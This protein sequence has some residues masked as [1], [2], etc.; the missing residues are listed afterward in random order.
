MVNYFSH[1]AEV[2]RL[3]DDASASVPSVPITEADSFRKQWEFVTCEARAICLMCSRRA[4]KTY[5]V[6]LRT[7][8]RS[9]ERPGWRTLI[10]HH[11]RILGK[12]QIYETGDA[13]NPGIREMLASH[14]IAERHHDSTDLNISLENGS[15]IQVVGCDDWREV[16]KKLG[17]LWN[18]IVMIECQE[19]PDAVLERLVDKTILPTLIDRGGSLTMEG[20]PA[21]VEAGVWFDT[22]MGKKT[23]F[24]Q[25]RWTL[26][27]NP[28]IDRQNIIDTMAIRGFKINFADPSD[29]PILI[30]REIFGRQVIDPEKLLYC[31]Q[32]GVNDW[33]AAGIPL[34]DS[35]AWRYAM[36]IDI[37]GANA[38]NDRDACVVWG[39]MVNDPE[40]LL[41]ER[42]SWE[43][44]EMD[45]EAFV[46]RVLGTYQRWPPMIAACG[47]TGGAG[48][49]KMLKVLAG[50]FH[51][52]EFTPK[53]TSVDTSTRLL[54]DEFRSG[55]ARVNPLGLIARDAKICTKVETY[56][57]DI[58]AA[59]R[60]GHH[61]VYNYMA[62]AD[63]APQP[64]N[65]D[66]AIRRRRREQ[67]Q[68]EK[69]NLR[70]PWSG[71]GGWAP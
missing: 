53:P 65:T 41:W 54:N 11:T 24:T 49:N 61:G 20:T 8:K 46:K 71:E 13:K 60:Y 28:F 3:P 48:A 19:F 42:E 64:E 6:R 21:E 29:N 56:H 31:Y 32:P 68:N 50:R 44:R 58:M 25:F 40:H 57:S 63:P 23:Q 33:P 59:A 15:F 51:G 10:I 37:G 62:K 18:D 35:Q 26:L 55:R 45:S 5:G 14:H 16:G 17:F 34:V 7:V 27:D 69:Q 67:W 43:E 22:I 9:H 70:N 38:G 1:A 4:A 2:A 47:D 36:G 39:W 66:E 30:Q 52:L 12:Q